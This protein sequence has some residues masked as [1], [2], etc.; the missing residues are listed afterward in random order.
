M[1][2]HETVVLGLH[3]SACNRAKRGQSL[4]I[5]DRVLLEMTT[6]AGR[7]RYGERFPTSDLC[8]TVGVSPTS[9]YG[10]IRRLNDRGAGILRFRE[11]PTGEAEYYFAKTEEEARPALEQ[12][13]REEGGRVKALR[14][15]YDSLSRDHAA[16]EG[17][18]P[19]MIS[20]DAYK[21]ALAKGLESGL[22]AG[23]QALR[24]EDGYALPAASA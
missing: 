3:A 5:Q 19:M 8:A 21:A 16:L 7:P 13:A 12:Q 24:E 4:L 23:L 14:E 22:A 11:D 17:K 1:N 9:L 6:K 10:A 15:K 20:G 18:A 2:H